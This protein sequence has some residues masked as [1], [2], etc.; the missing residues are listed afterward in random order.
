LLEALADY[1]FNDTE[2]LILSLDELEL[3]AEVAAPTTAQALFPKLKPITLLDA[4][5]VDISIP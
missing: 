1:F 5:Q 4:P 3:A 2:V